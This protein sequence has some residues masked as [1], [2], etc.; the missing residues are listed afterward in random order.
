[1]VHTYEEW[2][3]LEGIDVCVGSGISKRQLREILG[4]LS[5]PLPFAAPEDRPTV[6]AAGATA[7]FF[8]LGYDPVMEVLSN[9]SAVWG[10]TSCCSASSKRT[11]AA[12]AAAAA[13]PRRCISAVKAS[14]ICGAASRADDVAPLSWLRLPALFA[15]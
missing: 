12:T 14:N 13:R 3:T 8:F 11:A 5:G 15:S 4:F 2:S 1:M 6:P 9:E 10:S 7:G